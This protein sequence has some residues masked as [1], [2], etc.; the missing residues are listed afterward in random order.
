MII[1]IPTATKIINAR[2]VGYVIF[3]LY[4]PF[5]LLGFYRDLSVERSIGR[6]RRVFNVPI[7]NFFTDLLNL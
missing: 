2:L 3:E 6:M 1:L 5:N 4:Y 7:R